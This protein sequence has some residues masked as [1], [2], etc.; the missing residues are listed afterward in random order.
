MAGTRASSQ[1]ASATLTL[2]TT[3][4]ATDAVNPTPARTEN[5]LNDDAVGESAGAEQQHEHHPIVR[6]VINISALFLSLFFYELLY[7]KRVRNVKK[8]FYVRNSRSV[9]SKSMVVRF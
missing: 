7:Q 8:F 3:T 5:A 2:T 9:R 6:R 1:N 4:N